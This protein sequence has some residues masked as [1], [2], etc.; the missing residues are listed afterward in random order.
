MSASETFLSDI[1]R[2]LLFATLSGLSTTLGAVFAIIR[3]PDHAMLAG[4]L[5]VAIGVMSTVSI[6]ELIVKNAM[7]HDT[8]LVLFATTLGA[9]AYYVCEPLIPKAEDHNHLKLKEPHS[10]PPPTQAVGLDGGASSS[11]L[12]QRKAAMQNSFVTGSQSSQ[13]TN[14]NSFNWLKPLYDYGKSK[15][16]EIVHEVPSES[17]L[18][19]TPQ[20][21]DETC[22]PF[23]DSFSEMSESEKSANLLRLGLLMAVTMTLHNMPEGFAVAF[24]AF[25]PL[26]PVMAV[27]IALHNI[28]EGIIIAA[29]IYAATGNRWKALGLATASGLSEPLGALLSLL[30]LHPFLTPERLQYLLAG[31][32]GLMLAVC[33]IELWPEARA[34]RNDKGL[35]IGI[36][37]GAVVMGWT[38]YIESA[39]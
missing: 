38:L 31:T 37:V 27:A 29:P 14:M 11:F 15:G 33:Y 12:A 1:S 8:F 39:E 20:S 34:C 3:R 9:L 18:V 32:G 24:S 23:G 16:T 21:F 28:P 10:P 25:T 19:G 6:V 17:H 36:L 22:T 5:G 26:G 4:L 2:P 7:E 13:H 35:I 30:L